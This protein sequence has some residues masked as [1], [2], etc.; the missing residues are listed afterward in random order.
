MRLEK[1]F[2]T[3]ISSPVGNIE[4]IA[5]ELAIKR[6]N[7]LKNKK[8]PERNDLKKSE[9]LSITVKQL[10]EYF[11]GERKFFDLPLFIKGTPMQQ[12]VWMKI[13]EI[14]IGKTTSYQDISKKIKKP[15]AYR[16][17]GTA[18]GK[19]SLPIVIPC[20]RVI[21]SNGDISGFSAG[22]DIKRKLLRFEGVIK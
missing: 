14:P 2:R 19:N 11:S 6:I 21:H 1:E 9:V 12:Q 10:K 8:K 18:V 20:H 7:F 4:I 16:A 5:N 3:S 17:V 13:L 15:N 22:D